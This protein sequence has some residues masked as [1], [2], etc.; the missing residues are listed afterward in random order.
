[1]PT[2][3]VILELSR[4]QLVA[5]VVVIVASCAFAFLIGIEEGLV[6]GR[7]QGRRLAQEAAE[8]A[9]QQLRETAWFLASRRHR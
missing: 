5:C 1:M 6:R 9:R 7:R 3:F 4:F 2:P 8:K